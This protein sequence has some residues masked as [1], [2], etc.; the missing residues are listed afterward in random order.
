M[1]DFLKAAHKM[2]RKII[3]GYNSKQIQ[4]ASLAKR[5]ARYIAMSG[6]KIAFSVSSQLIKIEA[7]FSN[8]EELP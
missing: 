6:A 1:G 5:D 7:I 2:E 8:T 4:A 3:Q